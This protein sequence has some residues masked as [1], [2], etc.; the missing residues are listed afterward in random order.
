MAVPF[1]IPTNSAEGSQFLC[2]LSNS[3]FLFCFDSSHLKGVKWYVAV[4]LISIS[5][6]I[7]DVE[8]F[9]S[10]L[11]G[12]NSDLKG[13]LGGLKEKNVWKILGVSAQ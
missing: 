12:C 10:F 5:L 2:I 1:H 11:D 8:T 4:V 3:Y 7:S 6:M 9:S 13:W